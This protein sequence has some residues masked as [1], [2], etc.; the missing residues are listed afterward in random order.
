[1]SIVSRVYGS[2]FIFLFVSRYCNRNQCLEEL[3]GPPAVPEPL[4]PR[5]IPLETGIKFEDSSKRNYQELPALNMKQETV[6]NGIV[7]KPLLWSYN[8][9]DKRIFDP[10]CQL[11]LGW[12]R[13]PA[14]VAA[15]TENDNL[16][17]RNILLRAQQMSIG[18]WARGYKMAAARPESDP[19]GRLNPSSCPAVLLAY[20]HVPGVTSFALSSEG[21]VQRHFPCARVAHIKSYRGLTLH[22][23]TGQSSKWQRLSNACLQEHR[24]ITIVV[25][26]PFLCLLS[27][28]NFSSML[29]PQN[30]INYSVRWRMPSSGMLRCMALVMTDVS[31]S[32]WQ[33]SAR[34]EFIP[35]Q[36]AT[37]ASYS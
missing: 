8:R 35:L 27:R 36:R 18:T 25:F 19:V 28:C 20:L 24:R 11:P 17:L 30:Y 13:V 4:F 29:Q 5:N 23:A 15:C 16:G 22:E 7:L 12:G 32:E 6:S 2:R 9:V 31:S 3:H 21:T 26:Y 14:G 34:Y 33:E 1:L 10:S 37:V